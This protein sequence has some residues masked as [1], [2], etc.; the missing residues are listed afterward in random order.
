[1]GIMRSLRNL[2][3]WWSF[4]RLHDIGRQAVVLDVG[5]GCAPNMRSNILADKF[6]LDDSERSQPLVIDERPFIMC[7]A[8]HLPFKDKSFDYVI[9]SHVAEH[10]EEPEVLLAELSR[11]ATAGYIE[12]PG[13]IR[14]MFHGWDYHRWYV[15]VDADHL[16]F[17]EKPAPLHDPELHEWSA[18][19]FETD[20]VFEQ[21]FL[22]NMERFGLVTAFEWIGRVKSIV[23]RLPSSD[24][25]RTSARLETGG[26][27]TKDELS[28]QLK[29]A[30]RRTLSRNERVKQRLAKISRRQ[31]DPLAVARLRSMLCC[32]KCKGDLTDVSEGLSCTVCRA[33]FPVVGNV[34]YL[35]PE[36]I[37]NWQPRLSMDVVPAH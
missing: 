21:F 30:P 6:L 15:H 12:C 26:A 20:L 1:M 11:V 18:R 32:P 17:E 31:S 36:Q 5:C 13:R 24:W 16:V 8:L 23:R 9:C 4:P 25:Q 29:L 10:V 35:V 28:L 33:D 27:L 3:V 34:Y 14:E 22:D 19:H 37:V 7:D 2:R